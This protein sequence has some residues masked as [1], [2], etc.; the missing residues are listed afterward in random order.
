MRSGLLR[1]PATLLQL[2]GQPPL[3]AEL[4]R[5][6]VG[7][8]RRN[9]STL[10]A[11]SPEIRQPGQVTLTS[12]YHSRVMAGRYLKI[13][14]VFH[15]I[16]SV[17]DRTGKRAEI[18]IDCTALAGEPAVYQPVAVGVAA[19]AVPAAVLQDSPYVG[20]TGKLTEIRYRVQIPFIALRTTWARG[21][22]VT[23]AGATYVLQ[24]LV[25]DG[26]DGITLHLW[27]TVDA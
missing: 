18:E 23:V 8:V 10:N 2:Q 1:Q 26:A 3:P 5:L 24:S 20:G 11:E 27:A 12:R 6:W 14:G 13:A 15:Y 7:K 4:A 22:T 21:D 9:T 16:N 17:A 25:S 19:Y